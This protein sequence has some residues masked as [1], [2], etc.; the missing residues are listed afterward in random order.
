MLTR[1]DIGTC[2]AY[3]TD[4]LLP[5]EDNLV[6]HRIKMYTDVNGRGSW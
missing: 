3:V 6:K 5:L 2:L 4:S 1:V